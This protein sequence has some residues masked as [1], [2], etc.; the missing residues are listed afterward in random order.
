[1]EQAVSE[2]KG[3][4]DIPVQVLIEA[5]PLCM[6]YL[7]SKGQVLMKDYD[8]YLESIS[9]DGKTLAFFLHRSYLKFLILLLMTK[10]EVCTILPIGSIASKLCHGVSWTYRGDR[11]EK[12]HERISICTY[13]C[14]YDGW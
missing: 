7:N 8:A 6:P 11:D 9:P 12:E 4:R 2:T 14:V 13:L 5:L 3:D 1:M 10:T